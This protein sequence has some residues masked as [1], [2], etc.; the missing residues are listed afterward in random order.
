MKEFRLREVTQSESEPGFCQIFLTQFG[1]LKDVVHGASV[2]AEQS[3]IDI[4]QE[5]VVHG[6]VLLAGTDYNL[7]LIVRSRVGS[8]IR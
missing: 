7:Q 8:A 1:R 2:K 3:G 4:D 5:F 6:S